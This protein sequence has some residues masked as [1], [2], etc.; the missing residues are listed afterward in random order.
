MIPDSVAVLLLLTLIAAVVYIRHLQA[1]KA[2][3][4]FDGYLHGSRAAHG[5]LTDP[6]AAKYEVK[7]KSAVKLYDWAEDGL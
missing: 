2:L 1:M 4:Y 6:D 7:P 5:M 3:A